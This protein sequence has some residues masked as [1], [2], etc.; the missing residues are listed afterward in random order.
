[1]L[2]MFFGQFYLIVKNILVEQMHMMLL[3][4]LINDNK[5]KFVQNSKFKKKKVSFSNRFSSLIAKLESS[6]STKM[7]TLQFILVPI[8]QK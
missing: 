7:S 1:M 3:N 5:I 4:I 8:C 2:E 6:L